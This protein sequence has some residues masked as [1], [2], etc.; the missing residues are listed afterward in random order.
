[1]LRILHQKRELVLMKRFI[2]FACM[3]CA[4]GISGCAGSGEQIRLCAGSGEIVQLRLHKKMNSNIKGAGGNLSVSIVKFEDKRLP[5]KHLGSHICRL[6]GDAYFDLAGGD[7]RQ[8]ISDAFAN[9]L[10][11][12]GFQVNAGSNR[13]V[14]VDIT[15]RINKFSAKATRN[16]FSTN[17]QVDMIMEFTI[18][19]RADGSIVHMI[20]GA[21]GTN[22]VAF[23]N[24]EDMEG[25]V[26]EVLQDS[27]EKLLERTEVKGK[28]LRQKN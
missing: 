1:M 16:F 20:I 25:L 10:K 11:I 24:P 3:M 2:L 26:N 8:G 23:F 17:A 7:L 27:F 4:L 12:S 21:G 6:A 19:N 22:D 9:F 5:S 15:G 13:T 14:D 18:T 28:T